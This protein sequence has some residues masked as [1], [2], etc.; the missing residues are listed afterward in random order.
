MLW[1]SFSWTAPTSSSTLRCVSQLEASCRAKQTAVRCKLPCDANCRA[2]LAVVSAFL[3]RRSHLHRT[4]SVLCLYPPAAHGISKHCCRCTSA[5]CAPHGSSRI[6]PCNVA[7]RT[8]YSLPH[9][10]SGG[11]GIARWLCF[12]LC[13]SRCLIWCQEDL[14]L[15][16]PRASFEIRTCN[17]DVCSPY[18]RCLGL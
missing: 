2:M 7:S 12:F 18:L 9:N 16:I 1:R 5:R 8:H 11:K 14:S 15:S 6:A 17:V 10:C 4:H 13:M 3:S